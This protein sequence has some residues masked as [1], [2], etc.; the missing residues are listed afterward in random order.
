MI[1]RLHAFFMVAFVAV[2]GLAGCS[3]INPTWH[4]RYGWKAE[5]YFTDSKVIALC[6]AIEADDLKEIDRLVADGADVNAIGNGNM[7][8]L[9]WAFPDDKI[10]RFQRLLERGANPNVVVSSDFN[11]KGNIHRG[12]SVT[13]LAAGSTFAK[14]FHIV[15]QHGGDTKLRDSRLGRSLFHTVIT[16]GVSDKKVRIQLLLGK[17][18]DVNQS[19]SGG[20]TPIMTAVSWGG[21]YDIALMLLEAGADVK[22]YCKGSNQKLVHVVAREERLHRSPSPERAADYEALVQKLKELGESVDEAK[23]D[24][25]RWIL[26]GKINEPKKAKE[27]RDAEVAERVARERAKADKAVLLEGEKQ[28]K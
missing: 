6:R 19:D 18:A 8:P 17:G 22:L 10:T 11:T 23:H 2:C 25:D 1:S 16:S 20:F 13:H 24:L 28:E 7:T 15:M 9:L 26:R 14:H 21:Q 12:H 27:L 5:D 3:A 4:T